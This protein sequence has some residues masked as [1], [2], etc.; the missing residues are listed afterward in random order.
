[1]FQTM[2]VDGSKGRKRVQKPGRAYGFEFETLR[3]GY[4]VCYKDGNGQEKRKQVA[5]KSDARK[6]LE[7]EGNPADY[8]IFSY[9]ELFQP[10]DL[11]ERVIFSQFDIL[12]L[13]VTE[14]L[15]YSDVALNLGVVY[16]GPAVPVSDRT[17]PLN[18]IFYGPNLR[19]MVNLVLE[20]P[21]EKKPVNIIF[22]VDT[23]GPHFYICETAMKALGFVKC[24]ENFSVMF[25]KQVLQAEKSA[26]HYADINVLGASFLRHMKATLI[27]NY[28]SLAFEIKFNDA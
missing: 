17:A 24:P 2:N 26:A 7:N 3:A 19:P 12:L 22:L 5:T 11:D 23:G 13:D 28:A 25:G 9:L 10:G 20:W 21:H 15:L 4:L 16:L 27:L 14:E 1:M 6:L 18:G 8:E